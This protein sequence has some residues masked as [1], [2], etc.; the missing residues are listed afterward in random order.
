MTVILAYNVPL[1]AC[2]ADEFKCVD[3]SRCIPASERCDG[4]DN[5][6]DA[7]DEYD[8]EGTFLFCFYCLL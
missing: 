4:I 8:C 6:P 5:C 2:A 3:Y 1:D 7:S